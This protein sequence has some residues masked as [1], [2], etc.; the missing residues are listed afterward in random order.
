MYLLPP[1]EGV[2]GKDPSLGEELG[3]LFYIIIM[4]HCITDTFCQDIWHE[5]EAYETEYVWQGISEWVCIEYAQLIYY[6]IMA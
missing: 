1:L 3:G 2:R 4:P 5:C 6:V